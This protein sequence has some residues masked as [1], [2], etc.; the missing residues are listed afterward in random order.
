MNDMF[1]MLAIQP[2]D[3]DTIP[4]TSLMVIFSAHCPFVKLKSA[5]HC[6]M[7]FGGQ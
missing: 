5:S 7:G 2:L 6:V 1:C 3:D 4:T